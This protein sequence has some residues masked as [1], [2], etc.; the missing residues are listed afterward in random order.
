MKYVF[1]VLLVITAGCAG[2]PDFADGSLDSGTLVEQSLL[3]PNRFLVS[4]QIPRP[5][6]DDLKKTVIIAAHGFSATTYEWDEFR[7][8]IDTSAGSGSTLLS[9]VLLGGHGRSYAA[10][11]ASGWRDWQRSITHEYEKLVELG[12]NNI[13]FAGSSTGCALIMQLFAARYFEGKVQ[14]KAVFLIDP[15]VVPSDKMLSIVNIAG[16]VLGFVEA[17]NEPGEEKYWYTF[18]PQETL[19]ELNTL[20]VGLRKSLEK[21]I[22]TGSTRVTVFKSI[23]DASADPVSAVLLYKGVRT[24]SGRIS[25]LMIDSDLHVFTRL[26]LRRGITEKNRTQQAEAFQ[27]IIAG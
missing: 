5:S 4:E 10:F 25:V 17:E 13:V 8:F 27:R 2:D 9:Q 23:K 22:D 19:Q 21:G 15:I 6:P 18:R 16:P 20:I 12:Y 24:D 26:N 11:K 14:P 7:T 3:E 1:A